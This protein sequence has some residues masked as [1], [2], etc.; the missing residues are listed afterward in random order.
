MRVNMRRGATSTLEILVISGLLIFFVIAPVAYYNLTT[1]Y[2]AIT[3]VFNTTLQAVSIC[4][5]YDERVEEQLYSNL[6]ARGMLDSGGLADIADVIAEDKSKPDGKRQVVVECTT[7]IGDEPVY[8]A[9]G[10]GDDSGVSL[11]ISV[12]VSRQKRFL[13]AIS[14]LI[15][16]RNGVTD[17][18]FTVSGY[19]FSQL[20]RPV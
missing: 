9:H 1:S 10:A 6:L 18:Y 15:G 4:G 20:P 5:G 17:G 12:L 14:S 11:K 16:V 7:G 3:S 2:M 13:A 19:I 8:R